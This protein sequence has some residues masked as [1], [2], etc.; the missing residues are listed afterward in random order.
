MG[1]AFLKQTKKSVE[2]LQELCS[3]YRA[4]QDSLLELH[5]GI[6]AREDRLN[7][8]KSLRL[9]NLPWPRFAGNIMAPPTKSKLK[10][11]AKKGEQLEV[12]TQLLPRGA[13]T[14]VELWRRELFYAVEAILEAKETVEVQQLKPGI[15]ATFVRG[16]T[17]NDK[18]QNLVEPR[19]TMEQPMFGE[20]GG[21]QGGESIL[22][23]ARIVERLNGS[24][25]IGG[26]SSFPG[27]TMNFVWRDW[28]S[29]EEKKSIDFSMEEEAMDGR[30]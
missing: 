3:K 17:G 25:E 18:Q 11:V 24:L 5:E 7:D 9:D 21:V 13:F 23:I 4:Y 27:H 14:I 29:L 15:P 22:D 8:P 20:T 28:L 2:L 26:T 1:K 12:R 10:E 19:L 6:D 30:L 16:L